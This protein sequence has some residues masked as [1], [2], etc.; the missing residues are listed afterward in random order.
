MN[1]VWLYTPVVA[2]QGEAKESAADGK[3]GRV[4]SC[5]KT[6]VALLLGET[7]IAADFQEAL[8][9]SGAS[10]INSARASSL[11]FSQF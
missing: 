4:R 7:L 11:V 1:Q 9:V 10:P 8:A 3:L 5:T 6:S 2:S